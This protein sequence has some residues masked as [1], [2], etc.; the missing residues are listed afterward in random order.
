[1]RAYKKLNSSIKP[2]LQ[3]AIDALRTHPLSG[4]QVKQLKGQL[5]DYYR[6][7]AGDYRIVYTVAQQARIV[8][9]D[10]IQH[11]NDVYRHLE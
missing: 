11:R 9:I 7:R 10:Y 6:Y 4:P 2:R 8:S 1:M 3:A 5:R